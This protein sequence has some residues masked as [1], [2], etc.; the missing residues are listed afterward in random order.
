M[1]KVLLSIGL[2]ITWMSAITLA[3]ITFSVYVSPSRLYFFAFMGY[4]FPVF[5]VLNLLILI[6][7]I[8]R[9][10]KYLI[11]PLAVL[12]LG[13]SQWENIFQLKG[14]TIDDISELKNPVTIMSFNVKMFDR[15]NWSGRKDILDGT[16]D[17]IRKEN[18][19]I[20]C[21]QEFYAT[22]N[23]HKIPENYIVNRLKQYPYRHIEYKNSTYTIGSAGMALF[24]KYPIR[25]KKVIRFE[26]TANFTIQTDIEIRGNVV[27]VFDSHLESIRLNNRDIEV[28][29]SIKTAEALEKE[30]SIKVVINKLEKAF[31]KRAHQAEI[32]SRHISNSP[33][34][35]IVCGDFNDIPVSY[36][37][38]K[39]RGD[40]KDAFVEAG[41]GFGGTY[42]GKLPSFRIDYILFDPSFEAYNFKREFIDLSDHYPIMTI[43]D[44]GAKN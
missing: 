35:V 36:V 3:I 38:R 28:I 8:L 11:I 43:L 6:Y 33:Y 7:W 31:K 21:F 12:I 34:P 24:S 25:A 18:P 22:N 44:I 29:G 39:M 41:K 26:N 30:K 9:R 14:K 16:F 42:N 23:N 4:L 17:Y 32:I 40:L 37:Y 5:W 20:V 13:W 2:F 1:K 15:Y 19:D 27:R 10:K